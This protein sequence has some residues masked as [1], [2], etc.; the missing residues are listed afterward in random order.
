M[1]RKRILITGGYGFLG[2]NIL[3]WIDFN[4]SNVEVSVISSIRSGTSN[5][6]KFKCVKKLSVFLISCVC[7][8]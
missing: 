6:D 5:N 8:I 1:K 4:L 2:K 7:K 3:H